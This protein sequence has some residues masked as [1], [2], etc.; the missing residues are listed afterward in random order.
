M[1]KLNIYLLLTL[2]LTSVDSNSFFI[3][4]E[5]GEVPLIYSIL[6]LATVLSQHTI[7]QFTISIV[8]VINND[9]IF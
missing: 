2:M 1:D 9:K 8:I 4:K 5:E 3:T 6:N 7:D